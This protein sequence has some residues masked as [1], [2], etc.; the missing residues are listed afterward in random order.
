MRPEGW[1]C[2]F[3]G[4]EG[5]QDTRFAGGLGAMICTDCIRR[6]SEVLA[7]DPQT[8]KLQTPPWEGMSDGELLETLPLISRSTE[9]GHAFLVMWVDALR[10]RKVSWAQ[11]GSAL[12]VSRQAAWERFARLMTDANAV[13]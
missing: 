11:I 1:I 12:G 6:Y 7:S 4:T 5:T 3:C 10:V 9:Q 8:K 2:S 13:G